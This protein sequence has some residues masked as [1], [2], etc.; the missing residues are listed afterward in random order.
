MA[1]RAV[2]LWLFALVPG[3]AWPAVRQS[4]PDGFLIEHRF[5]IAAPPAAAWQVLVHPERWWPRD[6]TWSGNPGN[7]SLAPEAGGC[8]CERWEDGS[9]E[10]GRIIQARRDR[11]LRF[12]GALGPLQEMAV[13][14]V[15]TVMLAPAGNGTEATVTY[16]VS[17]DASHKLDG[18]VTVVDA[19]V[20]QQFGGFAE[21]ASRPPR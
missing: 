19:V 3:L 12:N 14:G 6:H 13:T 17:G 7:L 18:F 9:A 16:R 21:L 10:H 20:G 15:L 4:A 8:F 5:Q 2:V 11:T 1:Y